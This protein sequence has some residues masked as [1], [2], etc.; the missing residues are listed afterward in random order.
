MI[1]KS[2]TLRH[3]MQW[4]DNQTGYT[5]VREISLQNSRMQMHGLL[6]AQ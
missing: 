2:E 1:L 4:S 6:V 3:L 5:E